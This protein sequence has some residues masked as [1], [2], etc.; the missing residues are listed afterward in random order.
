VGWLDDRFKDLVKTGR[1]IL[2]YAAMAAPFVNYYGLP[3]LMSKFSMGQKAL[4]AMDTFNKSKLMNS[5]FGMATKEGLMKYALAAASGAENPEKVGRRAFFSSF[6]YSFLKTGGDFSQ[7][8]G[9][10]PTPAFEDVVVDSMPAEIGT[11][12]TPGYTEYGQ[13]LMDK[14]YGPN[15]GGPAPDPFAYGDEFISNEQI[16]RYFQPLRQ[17]EDGLAGGW[18]DYNKFTD[19]FD[20]VELPAPGNIVQFEKSPAVEGFTIS[21][22]DIQGPV[23]E[24][25]MAEA[26]QPL[27][28]LDY[29]MREKTKPS[30]FDTLMKKEAPI[31]VEP[32]SDAYNEFFGI[33]DMEIDPYYIGKTIFDLMAGGKTEGDLAE[34]EEEA[35][36]KMLTRMAITPY[37]ELSNFLGNKGGIASLNNG[38]MPGPYTDPMMSDD[39]NVNVQ[40]VLT[41]PAY[42]SIDDLGNLFEEDVVMSAPH[43]MEGWY[44]MY[45][46]MKNSGELPEGI[47]TF[48]EF[49]EFV[50]P[51]MDIDIPMAAKGG[52]LN[53]KDGLWANIHAKRE[54]I[55][56]G[57]GEKMRKPGSKGAPTDEALRQSQAYGGSSM[58]LN[59]IPGG[60]ISG[61]GTETSDSIPAQLSNNEFVFTADAVRAA[62]GG[63]IDAGA[64]KMYSM[65]N[66]LDPDS[67]KPGD[68]PQYA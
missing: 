43:P 10:T 48:D 54:R 50:V 61:P 4:T 38:G 12:V 45:D 15:R 65:M 34:D 26:E 46:D 60:A 62:G 41:S 44:D 29:V 28:G 6:P 40:D 20:P 55:K 33:G 31:G 21:G 39:F 3:A 23:T 1:E 24:S 49:M 5:A 58:E 22:E 68:P 16:G 9:N 59:A 11:R 19:S 8:L 36:Q 7:M 25:M 56:K 63:D 35:Y 2:P 52:R 17:T 47:K 57:S 53:A 37:G 67:A 18:M 13:S 64:Q 32:G 30:I 27:S 14:Y 42:E 66:A 51:E